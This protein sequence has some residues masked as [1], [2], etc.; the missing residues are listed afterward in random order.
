MIVAGNSRSPLPAANPPGEGE[1]E[2]FS[3]G[4]FRTLQDN[5][6]PID[7]PDVQLRA[8]ELTIQGLRDQPLL[9]ASPARFGSLQR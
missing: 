6:G 2:I 1:A 7:L 8:I 3:A 4:H 9:A 5:S